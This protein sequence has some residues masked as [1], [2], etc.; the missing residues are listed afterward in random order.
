MDT[1]ITYTKEEVAV[2]FGINTGALTSRVQ[3]NTFPKP[4]GLG[5]SFLDAK[6]QIITINR[7][8]K[9]WTKGAL[10]DYLESQKKEIE[11]IEGKIK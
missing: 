6:G 3:R 11:A 8:S 7:R 5:Q 10:L 4:D 1:E 9:T 2:F